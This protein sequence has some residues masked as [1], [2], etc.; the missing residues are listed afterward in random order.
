MKKIIVC[1]VLFAITLGYAPFSHALPPIASGGAVNYDATGSSL[2]I[3]LA[4]YTS[5]PEGDT[6]HY[7][8]GPADTGEVRWP[9]NGSPNPAR[10]IVEYT[11]FCAFPSPNFTDQFTYYAHDI[12]ENLF[13]TGIITINV[14]CNYGVANFDSYNVPVASGVITNTNLLSN[15]IVPSG[16][17]FEDYYIYDGTNY[18]LLSPGGS[19][20]Y[21]TGFSSMTVTRSTAAP[22][23]NV[24]I[25]YGLY[26]GTCPSSFSGFYYFT[27]NDGVTSGI[28][29]VPTSI[30]ISCTP[31]SGSVAINDTIGPLTVGNN[32]VSYNI[33]GNDTTNGTV[34][35]VTIS[36]PVGGNLI[37]GTPI[38]WPNRGTLLQN[39]DNTL[40]FTPIN[41][42]YPLEGQ[43]PALNYTFTDGNGVSN[44]A[45]IVIIYQSLPA[46]MPNNDS[47]TGLL[48]NA[49]VNSYNFVGNDNFGPRT[50]T[51]LVWYDQ[52]GNPLSI[53]QNTSFGIGNYGSFIWNTGNTLTF[54]PVDGLGGS[55]TLQYALQ[56]VQNVG[57]VIATTTTSPALIVLSYI[58]VPDSPIANP[59]INVNLPVGS[60]Q[61]LNVLTNDDLQGSTL[62]SLTIFDGV[63]SAVLTP[64]NSAV[65]PGKG[66]VTMNPGN[67]LTFSPFNGVEGTVGWYYA[68]TYTNSAEFNGSRTSN[69]TLAVLGYGNSTTVT[70]TITPPP[71]PR[72]GTDSPNLFGTA[73]VT[74]LVTS[75]V[76]L[77]WKLATNYTVQPN[78]LVVSKGRGK[79]VQL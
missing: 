62:Q 47:L 14:N 29:T 51:G 58:P 49:T 34:T 79:K 55:I 50:I 25:S 75:L 3:D 73:L 4:S 66:S 8:I 13:S 59:D 23:E 70:Q 17:T 33:L 21:N 1:V 36:N 78:A 54:D 60:Q 64:S 67:S 26:P 46:A 6:I 63:F 19:V 9:Q 27:Y 39:L 68:F 18:V 71:S 35:N 38:I 74:A 24:D 30:D 7:G 44:T 37:P 76:L 20:S 69:T 48:N 52:F 72:T 65:I 31:S 22:F 57:G 16:S 11:Y 10:S 5:D 77:T 12:V 15:D 40:S 61:T 53:T 42:P 45:Q 32:V 2:Q 56:Y 43:L 41:T 28:Q